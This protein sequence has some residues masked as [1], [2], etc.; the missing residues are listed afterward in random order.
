[1]GADEQLAQELVSWLRKRSPDAVKLARLASPAVIIEPE[2]LRSLRVSVALGLNVGAEA[3]LWFSSLVSSRS[4]DAIT[5]KK[6]IAK[7]LRAQLR[8][9]WH[10]E[11]LE[12]QRLEAARKVME[13]VHKNLFEFVFV[14]PNEPLVIPI[15]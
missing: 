8:E 10:N 15:R 3:D 6:P 2:L 1:M 14:P 11:P 4:P 7:A 5:L 12:R 13:D 9:S